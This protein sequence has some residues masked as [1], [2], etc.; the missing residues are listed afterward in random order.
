MI[1]NLVGGIIMV[2]FVIGGAI[3]ADALKPGEKRFFENA[4]TGGGHGDEAE[5]SAD[6][7][8]E[9]AK[10]KKTAKK[11][12]HGGGH[13]EPA[14]TGSTAY[15]KFSRQFIV[16]VVSDSNVQSLVI[17]DLNLEIE[18]NL[19]EDLYAMDPKLR[20]VIMTELIALSNEGRFDRRMTDPAN[21]AE[22]RTRLLAAVQTI[23][24]KGVRDVLILDMARQD[25]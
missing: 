3:A 18:P 17:L 25:Q 13:G 10:E 16:P 15:Y 12:A 7:H 2:I 6:A 1:K 19:A 4:E 5:A 9:P 22:I 24:Q 23:Q 14:M 20:D 11:D 8:G 21:Y